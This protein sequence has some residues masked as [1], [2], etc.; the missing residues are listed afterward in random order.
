MTNILKKVLITINVLLLVISFFFVLYINVYQFFSLG[1]NPFENNFFD[2]FSILLPFVLL[3]CLYFINFVN[4][5]YIANNNIIYKLISIFSLIVILY[6]SYRS[7]FDDSLI[8]WHK[9]NY[10]INFDYFNNHL[11]YIKLVL[12]GLSFINIIFIVEGILEKRKVNN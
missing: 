1:S 10:H 12:Y 4:N 9:T 3:M 5:H 8:L 11:I 2:F 7:I 6:I